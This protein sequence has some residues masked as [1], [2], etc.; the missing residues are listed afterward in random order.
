MRKL[1]L[2]A[3]IGTALAGLTACGSKSSSSSS[4]TIACNNAAGA[5]TCASATGPQAAMT[6]GGYNAAGCTGTGGTVVASCTA[7]N[8]VGRCSVN[9]TYS[10]GTV[11]LVISFYSPTFT[12]MTGQAACAGVTG[13]TWTAG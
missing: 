12:A 8:R 10:Q 1:L 6:A 13:A 9:D 11:L 7:T 5:D 3:A 2:V 4:T